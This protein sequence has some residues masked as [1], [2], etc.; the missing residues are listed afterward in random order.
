MQSSRSIN[1]NQRFAAYLRKCFIVAVSVILAVSMM[2]V[3]GI[4]AIAAPS[5]QTQAGQTTSNS[6]SIAADQNLTGSSESGQ[7]AQPAQPSQSGYQGAPENQD[8]ENQSN[9][10]DG[11]VTTNN[12]GDPSNNS[13]SVTDNSTTNV[14]DGQTVTTL[15]D[16]AGIMPLSISQG[17]LNAAIANNTVEGLD[18]A[19]ATVNLF[20]YAVMSV[21]GRDTFD[22][23]AANWNSMIGSGINAN[24][25]LLFGNLTSQTLSNTQG[26]GIAAN[27]GGWWNQGG[28]SPTQKIIAP[29][30]NDAGYPV[31]NNLPISEASALTGRSGS[32]S[33]AY[34]FNPSATV[35]AA[36]RTSYTDVKGLFQLDQDTG[37]YYYDSTKNFAEAG[38]ADAEKKFRLWNRSAVQHSPNNTENGYFFP[39]N[40]GSQV[41]NY[42][43]TTEE[44]TPVSDFYSNNSNIDHYF[45][46]TLSVPFRQPVD[47]KTSATEPMRFSF[48]GDDDVWVFIDDVLV[49]DL[50]GMHGAMNLDINFAT[51]DVTVNGQTHTLKQSFADAGRADQFTS[52]FNENTFASNSA[53]TLK[54]F[55]LERGGWA[56]NLALSFNLQPQLFQQIRKVDQ[57]GNPVQGATF[58]LYETGADYQVAAGA[59]AVLNGIETDANGYARFALDNGEPFNF[60][61]RYNAATQAGHYYVLRETQ[62]PSGYKS[63]P[64]DLQLEFLP[65][66]TM[67]RVANRY[68]AGAFASFNSYITG[69][70]GNTHYGQMSS[71]GGLASAIEGLP[72]VSEDTQKNGLVVA[73]PMLKH[74]VNGQT[75]WNPLYGD[76][77]NVLKEVKYTAGD[78]DSADTRN[79]VRGAAL[80]AVLR[81]AAGSV[82]GSLNGWYLEWNNAEKR[83]KGA[84]ES[85]PGRPDRYLSQNGGDVSKSDMRMMYCLIEPAALARALGISEAQVA[86]LTADERYQQLG[87]AMNTAINQGGDAVQTLLNTIGYTGAAPANRGINVLDISSFARTFR[88]VIYIPNEQRELRVWKVDADGNRLDGC[89]FGLF[90]TEAAAQ[91]ATGATVSNNVVTA[92]TQA[93]GSSVAPGTGAVVGAGVT[94]L[95]QSGSIG[96]STADN[97]HGTLVFAPYVQNAAGTAQTEWLESDGSDP[98]GKMMYLKEVSAPEGYAVN[99]TVIPVVIGK[100]GIYADA[101]QADDGVQVLAGVGKLNATMRKYAASPDVNLTLRYITATAQRQASHGDTLDF[102]EF[103]SKWENTSRTMNLEY[104]QNALVDYGSAEGFS[105]EQIAQGIGYP[106]AY[107]KQRPLFVTDEGYIR[108]AVKQNTTLMERQHGD[109][110]AY[111][112]AEADSLTQDLTGLF[113]IRNTVRVQDQSVPELLVTNRVVTES[114]EIKAPDASFSFTITAT[115]KTD[116]VITARVMEYKD[117]RWVPTGV[118]TPVRFAGGT[119]AI[120]LKHGQG[121][122]IPGLPENAQ[123]SVVESDVL[124]GVPADPTDPSGTNNKLMTQADWN[125]KKTKGFAFRDVALNQATPS[126]PADRTQSVTHNSV[127]ATTTIT[128]NDGTAGAADQSYNATAIHFVNQYRVVQPYTSRVEITKTLQNRTF[129]ASDEFVFAL[130][131][132]PFSNPNGTV[133]MPAGAT[134]DDKGALTYVKHWRP[135][136][137]D[138]NAPGTTI[139]GATSY[140]AHF[141]IIAGTAG[142][143]DPNDVTIFTEPGT[144]TYLVTEVR[145]SQGSSIAGISYDP[146]VY[147]ITIEVAPRMENSVT[148]GFDIE[149]IQVRKSAGPSNDENAYAQIWAKSDTSNVDEAYDATNFVN[150]Y[151]ENVVD[152]VI[153]GYKNL[154]GHEGSHEGANAEGNLQANFEFVLEPL[155]AYQVPDATVKGQLGDGTT[156][157]PDQIATQLAGYT[158]ETYTP[159]ASAADSMAA[160][161]PMP[162]NT[163][164]SDTQSVTTKADSEGQVQFESLHFDKDQLGFTG[165]AADAASELGVVFKYQVREVQPTQ[166]GTFDGAPLEGATKIDTDNDGTPDAW[167]YQGTTYDPS[168]RTMYYYAHVDELTPDPADPSVAAGTVIHVLRYGETPFSGITDTG[169][170]APGQRFTNTYAA[171][172]TFTLEAEKLLNGVDDEGNPSPS[173]EFKPGDHFEFVVTKSEGAP[174]LRDAQGKSVSRIVIEPTSGKSYQF[175][176]G[177]ANFTQADIGKTYT[178]GLQET[179]YGQA[180]MSYDSAMRLVDVTISDQGDGTL[181]T[182]ATMRVGNNEP[183]PLTNPAKIAWINTYNPVLTS[184]GDLEITKKVVVDPNNQQPLTADY[185]FTVYLTDQA[186]NSLEGEYV[187]GLAGTSANAGTVKDGKAEFSLKD[188]Q[189]MIIKNLPQGTQYTVEEAEANQNCTTTFENSEGAAADENDTIAANA[190]ML[191]TN[192]FTS[193]PPEE[194]IEFDPEGGT[195]SVALTKTVAGD[196]GQTDRAFTFQVRL[197]N[198]DGTAINGWLNYSRDGKVV[199]GQLENGTLDIPVAHGQIVVIGAIPVG[200]HYTVTEVEANQ[201][202]YTTTVRGAQSAAQGVVAE[203]IRSNAQF[204]NTKGNVD[205]ADSPNSSAKTGDSTPWIPIAL[206]AATAVVVLG[207]ARVMRNRAMQRDGVHARR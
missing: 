103:N 163:T 24:H 96:S 117:T 28:N 116:G 127:S 123:V 129:A 52:G 69:V 126:T 88:S 101:G 201:D 62:A 194:F 195:G 15:G 151:N 122:S 180:G 177:T 100:Y 130:T 186:G 53:H 140:S 185:H 19:G 156:L 188:G 182:T 152:P 111:V 4:E 115:G 141:P 133:P 107:G 150:T 5:D 148:T 56:S 91:A 131:P 167:N 197:T 59:S 110:G 181:A 57:D 34:L 98:T 72:P 171:T 22:Y 160:R 75:T 139:N 43:T 114:N 149:P 12:S 61:D 74:S 84:L 83:L 125:A 161:Q 94:G 112:G 206:L 137:E 81:Q 169:T 82:D 95:P 168:V 90:S 146:S 121:V 38:V 159:G 176:L 80:E 66:T 143:P 14:P 142:N 31:L 157:T 147:A 30:L 172:G 87:A 196:Q 164:A 63:L 29:T 33:L 144:Y 58:D 25:A 165:N 17:D 18:P 9:S 65:D 37:N 92:I 120:S 108:S 154:F 86:A 189:S 119:A 134:A 192:D 153:R 102:D 67:L 50:G 113:M 20:D 136:T 36:V 16:Q 200:A 105:P 162:D 8:R 70:T 135:T 170:P 97:Q 23:T 175:A 179:V 190:R 193:V 128:W 205:G 178:Y 118:T 44:I 124:S 13:L 204:V 199:A 77:L 11:L 187:Y 48:T 104:G 47:G 191:V 203:N 64:T 60:S 7:P 54:M 173:Q 93:D 183:V 32:E 73:I 166:D 10:G 207:V 39:F 76:T 158:Y 45:G 40:S 6:S 89:V 99:P 184:V 26:T 145:P 2:P 78:L 46:M 109:G 49:A 198:A 138:V 79:A 41:F 68:D 71:G 55:Y 42:N 155:G 132:A 202:G 35:D 1:K 106:D 21:D 27:A 85:L 174:E 3:G 51:G